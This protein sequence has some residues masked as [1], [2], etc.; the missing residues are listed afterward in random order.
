MTAS[1]TTLLIPLWVVLGLFL[2]LGVLALLGRV[3]NGR[4]LRPIINL[5]AK[6]PL[7]KRWLEKASTAAIERSNP[8]LASAMKKMQ[9]SGALR[10]PQRAQA[11]LSNLTPQERRALIEMQD[12]QGTA[13]EG[14]NRQM[15][16]RMEKARRDAQRRGR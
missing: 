8:E 13:P 16:R 7:F 10:D 2:L 9:R 14:T 1:I 3:Q 12:E 5:I 6:V 15:R 4:Y 11:A